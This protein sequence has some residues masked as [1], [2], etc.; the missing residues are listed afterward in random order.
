MSVKP[1]HPK[2]I[3]SKQTILFILWVTIYK[4]LL[5]QK[6]RILSFVS[7][8]PCQNL[9][10]QLTMSI[11]LRPSENICDP[12]LKALDLNNQIIKCQIKVKV[13]SNV[14][15]L[16]CYLN[17]RAPNYNMSKRF[18]VSKA[19]PQITCGRKKWKR[20]AAIQLNK[21]HKQAWI[22][23]SKKNILKFSKNYK[24]LKTQYKPARYN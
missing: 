1:N 6:L 23:Y 18:L 20:N 4:Q 3:Q 9:K 16:Q 11:P 8:L 10:Y 24:M 14:V 19:Q 2:T 21:P 12:N 22:C 15:P 17:F 13:N 5:Q 7:V